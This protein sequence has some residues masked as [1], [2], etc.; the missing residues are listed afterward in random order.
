MILDSR[1]KGAGHRVMSDEEWAELLE[2]VRLEAERR[3][4]TGSATLL[5]LIDVVADALN[6]AR[7]QLKK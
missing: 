5:A 6:D 3:A 4:P 7:K 2:Q 1:G